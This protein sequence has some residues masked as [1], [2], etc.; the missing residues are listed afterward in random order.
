MSRT[1]RLEA[2]NIQWIFRVYAVAAFLGG[3]AITGWGPL[4]FGAHMADQPFGRAALVRV[5]GGILMAVA[6]CAAGLAGTEE[7]RAQKRGLFWFWLGHMVVF[8]VVLSQSYAIWGGGVSLTAARVL[9]AVGFILFSLWTTAEGEKLARPIGTILG[10]A[11]ESQE[12]VRSRYEEQIRAAARQEE[13][14]RL[15]RDLH[16]SIKQQIFVIQTA[17]ATAQAR[18]GGDEAGTRQALDQVRDSAREAMA[19]MEAMLDQMTA[20]PLENVGLVEAIRKQCEAFAFRTGA[21]VDFQPGELPRSESLPAG[22]HEAFLRVTQEALSNAARHARATKLRVSL[23]T[24][25]D[26]LRLSIEDDGAG[27]DTNRAPRGQGIGNIRTRADEFGGTFEL[28]SH[29]GRGTTIVFSIP[30]EQVPASAVYKRKAIEAGAAFGGMVIIYA[31]WV[32]SDN[33][34][35]WT[36]LGGIWTL[37]Y[38]VGYCRALRQAR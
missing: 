24:A 14:N 5:F 6:C 20:A 21:S 17:A 8:L 9:F 26:N 23:G 22:A 13:R 35:V 33:F 12:G 32:R 15:A 10:G 36:A 16:D 27:F 29:P 1:K 19:E 3:L 37:R 18:F 34:L 2:V 38:V 4:W 31:F 25:L 30:Y 11:A 7:P 28:A